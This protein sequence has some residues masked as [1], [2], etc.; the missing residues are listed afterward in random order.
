MTAALDNLAAV[1][2]SRSYNGGDRQPFNE[3]EEMVGKSSPGEHYSAVCRRD[4]AY[5]AAIVGSLS[6]KILFTS[7]T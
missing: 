3:A 4:P 1:I 6:W 2:D 7:K 5:M